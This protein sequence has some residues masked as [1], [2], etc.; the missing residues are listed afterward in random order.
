MNPTRKVPVAAALTALLATVTLAATDTEFWPLHVIDNTSRGADG[1]KLGDLNNDGLLDLTVGWEEGGV[2]RVYLHPSPKSAT[3]PWPAATIGKTPKAEDAVFADVN[4]DGRLDI[5]A[6]C[7][8]NEQTLYLHLAPAKNDL[9]HPDRWTQSPLPGSKNMTR[10]MFVTPATLDFGQDNRKVLI[11]GSKDPNGTIGYWEIPKKPGDEWTW[12]PLSDAGWIMSII[13]RDMD[14]DGDTDIYYND[15]KGN[16]RGAWW[17]ENPGSAD[18]RWNKRLIGGQQTELLFSTLSDLDGDGL[19][20]VLAT[21]KDNRIIWWRR[22]NASGL[23]WEQREV[24]YP[25]NAGTAKA[26]A[27]GDI[28]QD[29]RL[30][31]VVDCEHAIPPKEGVFWYRQSADRPFE[32]WKAL[33]L[34]GPKGVKFDRI[35]LIDI[36]R[37]GDLDVLTCEESHEVEG[38]RIGLGVIWYEN[39]FGR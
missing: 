14:G 6:S 36:D 16:L 17:L 13:P 8:G 32:N 21:A 38:K 22:L 15:R 26:V 19:E 7:E 34:S 28:D 5:I 35:E 18:H 25:E 30:D 10:W 29:G 33:P 4:G 24:E 37:D 3:N 31:L 2:T 20:D 27:V 11:A 12:R 23:A 1:V 39:P 9:L